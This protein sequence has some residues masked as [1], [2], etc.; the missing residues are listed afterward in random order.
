[1]PIPKV[2][3]LNNQWQSLT[4]GSIFPNQA[5]ALG[6][7]MGKLQDKVSKLNAKLQSITAQVN[8][9]GNAIQALVDSAGSTLGDLNAAG[10]Y[11]ITLTP[12]AG[13]WL[14][15]ARAAAGQQPANSGYSAGIIIIAQGPDLGAVTKNSK[16]LISS[17][18]SPIV[19]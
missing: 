9:K 12:G 16:T 6:D 19:P 18:T 10:L 14:D 4:L 17:I 3:L 15:R 7:K 13:G 11:K 8:A 5:N 1:M 2:T